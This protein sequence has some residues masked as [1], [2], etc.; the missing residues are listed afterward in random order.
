M[1]IKFDA[2][3]ITIM[4]VLARKHLTICSLAEM[5]P[6]LE[7][8]LHLYRLIF[9]GNQ[10]SILYLVLS[11]NLIFL[12]ILLSV[13]FVNDIVFAF[14]PLNLIILKNIMT[15]ENYNI[16]TKLNPHCFIKCLLFCKP[17]IIIFRFLLIL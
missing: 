15:F 10:L 16:S 12:L 5:S 13:I 11:F 3:W 8:I 1:F 4:Q 6:D 14:H 2:Y 17:L 7:S 9:C